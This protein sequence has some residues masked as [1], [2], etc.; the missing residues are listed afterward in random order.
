[1]QTPHVH[2]G[3]RHP[4]DA[5]PCMMAG[6]NAPTDLQLLGDTKTGV[7]GCK[8][9]GPNREQAVIL[10]IALLRHGPRE[11]QVDTATTGIAPEARAQKVAYH[12]NAVRMV[13]I[14]IFLQLST[15]FDIICSD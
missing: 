12:M 13:L 8:A 4:C 6:R 7:V 14:V 10:P 1:M 5:Y 9:V 11:V 15:I 3:G 2:T